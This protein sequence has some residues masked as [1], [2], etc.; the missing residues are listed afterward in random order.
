MN[1]HADDL[2]DVPEP[3]AYDAENNRN[4]EEQRADHEKAGTASRISGKT[5]RSKITSAAAIISEL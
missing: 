2:R 1:Q 5:L 3:G 4:E